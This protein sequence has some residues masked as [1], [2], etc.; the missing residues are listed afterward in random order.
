MDVPFNSKRFSFQFVAVIRFADLAGAHAV[1]QMRGRIDRFTSFVQMELD[2]IGYLA[3]VVVGIA[4]DV[5][6]LA[7]DVALFDASRKAIGLKEAQGCKETLPLPFAVDSNS[8]VV[9]GAISDRR[10][11]AQSPIKGSPD[12]IPFRT[13]QID[14]VDD[15]FIPSFVAVTGAIRSRVNALA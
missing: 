7:N 5:D 14:C 11:C 3:H 12:Q 2:K 13:L 4:A 9:T 10:K 8:D 1:L 15:L 6:P